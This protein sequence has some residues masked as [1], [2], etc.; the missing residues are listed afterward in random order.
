MSKTI[1]AQLLADIQANVTTLAT[2]VEIKRQDRRIIRLTNHDTAITFDGNVY[3]HLQP[4]TLS[5]IS[6]G[7]QF[8][9]DNCTLTVVPD[10]VTLKRIDFMKGAYDFSEVTVSLVDFTAPDDGRMIVHKGTFGEIKNSEIGAIDITLVGLLKV[11][12]FSV[13]RIYQP[14]CDADLGDKRCKVALKESQAY[15][16][17]NPYSTGDWVYRYAPAGM[18]AFTLTNPSFDADG[19]VGPSGTITGWTKG[20]NSGWIVDNAR[21]TYSPFHGTH[22]LWGDT[23]DPATADGSGAEIFAYQDVTLIPDVSAANIDAGKITFAMFANVI[24]TVYTLDPLRLYCEQLD[25][26]GDVIQA[27]DTKWVYFDTGL[28]G[29]W[30]ERA[31][32]FPLIAGARTVRMYVYGKKEHLDIVDIGFDNVRAYHWDHTIATPYDDVIHKCV[33]IVNYTDN[34]VYYPTNGSFETA[35]VANT[36]SASAISG[37]TIV[38]GDFW[39]VVSSLTPLSAQDGARFLAGGDNSSGVQ[40]EY[41]IY[42]EVTLANVSLIN[43]AR[44]TLGKIVGRLSLNVGWADTTSAAKV[45]LEFYNGGS[46]ITSTTVLDWTTQASTGWGTVNQTFTIPSTTTK[47]RTRLFARSPSGSSLANI[48]YDY[49][50]F[51][52]YD[53]ERPVKA[54]AVR[55]YGSADTVWDSTVG[56]YTFDGSLIWKAVAMF[57]QYNTVQTVIS[58][59]QFVVSSNFTAP[60]GTYE[61]GLIE[62]VSGDNKGRKSVVR[63]YTPTSVSPASNPKFK[64]YFPTPYPIQEDDAF[65]YYRPCAKRF[66]EDCITVFDNAINFRG[67]PHL[68]GKT[69][70]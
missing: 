3:D 30:Q 68:P 29:E 65:F 40:Q 55:G 53:A 62:W 67:F 28:F 36:S 41:E 13:G 60:V 8:E 49:V 5:S 2:L 25:V 4:F 52:F 70:K 63:N 58:D 33:R 50:R 21:F 48:A 45:V 19:D 24:Q 11:L 39:K 23:D 51:Y 69:T 18:T 54:D 59:K 44:K 46:L 56:S 35:L 31:L 14:S 7:S 22:A 6:K 42:N 27:S 15:S 57:R 10:E 17:L 47:I 38:S 64:L 20:P 34:N 26:N 66:T 12:D 9:V 32:V 16:Y 1:S 61:T 37:W 43:S